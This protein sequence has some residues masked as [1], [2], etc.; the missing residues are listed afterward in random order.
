MAFSSN[1]NKWKQELADQA[2][3][4]AVKEAEE[5]IAPAQVGERAQ[6]RIDAAI[7]DGARVE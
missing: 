6:A 3:A 1:L 7:A 5:G 4:E 2:I